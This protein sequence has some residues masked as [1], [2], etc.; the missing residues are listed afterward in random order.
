MILEP[1]EKDFLQNKIVTPGWYHVRINDVVEKP[2][3]AGDGINAW[4]KGEILQNADSGSKEFAGVPTPYLWLYSDKAPWGPIALMSALGAD[5]G[6]GKRM[7]VSKGSLAGREVIAF[8]GNA[9]GVKDGK[10]YNSI[11][12]QFKPVPKE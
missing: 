12:D 10:T 7:D 8:I 4:I 5:V 11:T 9:L 6:P 2:N 3:N 1:N